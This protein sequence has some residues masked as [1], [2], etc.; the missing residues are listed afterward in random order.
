MTEIEQRIAKIIAEQGEIDLAELAPSSTMDSHAI[1]SIAQLEILF[2]IEE[3]FDI[4]FPDD[5][6]KTA[7]NSAT[8]SDL[9]LNV[10]K[11]IAEKT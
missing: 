5:D 11:M 1:P 9:A 8:L 3:E 2:A 4:Y 6:D 10:E 7:G